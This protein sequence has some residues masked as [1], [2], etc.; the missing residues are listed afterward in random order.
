MSFMNF[1]LLVYAV[2]PFVVMRTE[3]NICIYLILFIACFSQYLLSLA[4]GGGI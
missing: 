2:Y 1:C 3:C 4:E